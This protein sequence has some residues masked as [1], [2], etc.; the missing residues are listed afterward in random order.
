MPV[1]ALVS[2]APL[3]SGTEPIEV[4]DGRMTELRIR[5]VAGRQRGLITAVLDR[6]HLR[7]RLAA[8]T[9][10]LLDPAHH[11]IGLVTEEDLSGVRA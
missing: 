3:T 7:D 8:A 10:Q 11:F 6:R 5:F 1:A 9:G 2:H 4:A